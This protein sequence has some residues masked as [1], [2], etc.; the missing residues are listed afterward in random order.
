M[1]SHESRRAFV[2]LAL[3]LEALGCRVSN[4]A[5][6]ANPNIL[7]IT[8]D[9][10]RA[11]HVGSYGYSAAETQ[12]LDGLAKRGLRFDR[13]VT[14]TPLTLPAHASLMT[15]TYPGYHGIRDNGGAALGEG[16]TTLADV[17]RARGYR[18][19][20]FVAAFVLDH[21]WG[22]NQGFDRYSDRV[23]LSNDLQNAGTDSAQRAGSEVVDEATT[24]L[25]EDTSRPFFAWVH[26]Y[27]PHTP[28]DA[29]E[30]VRARFPA[31]TAGAYDAEIAT[32]DEQVGRLVD[33]LS[34]D[35]RLDRT[36]VVALG[37]H[38]ESLGEHQERE[39]GFFIYDATVR[40]PLIV[41]GPGIPS[42]AIADQVRIVDVMPTL[43][44]LA[45]IAIPPAVQGTSLVPVTSGSHVQL[46]ALSETWYPRR[47]FGWSELTA[48]RDDR[49][50]F[51][52]APGRELYDRHL[53]PGE[54]HN[55]AATN[56]ERANSLERAL[57]ELIRHTSSE[58][59]PPS[60]RRVDART[61]ERLRSLGYVGG[62][63]TAKDGNRPLADPKDK[64]A[65]YN[66]LKHAADSSAQGQ[67]DQ[68][69]G[70]VRL[71][72][73]RDPDMVEG[74]TMLGD[75]LRKAKRE[76]DA[77]SAFQR[78]LTL[79]PHSTKSAWNVADIW[80][81]R[82]EFGKAEAALKPV[83][84]EA[85]DRPAFLTKL[86]ECQIELTRYDEA[87]QNLREALQERP[88]QP[89][90][91]YDL[92][93]IHE[94]RRESAQAMSEYEAELKHNPTMDRAHFNLGKLLTASG[95]KSDAARRFQAAVDAN[96]EFSGG[97]LY[98]AKARLDEG[99]LP[100]AEAAARKGLSL[101]P[102]RQ[103][104]PLGHYVLADVYN[105]LGRPQD[106]AREAAIGQRLERSR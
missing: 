34:R 45:G 76:D 40:I 100:R 38:G 48:I 75:F 106:S 4:R 58:A 6:V 22:I 29:P 102:D 28:Y 71:A 89:V 61:A 30:P 80:T 73:D 83:I 94:A 35:G 91:H 86:A 41:A 50:T 11:D 47:H 99:D 90:A 2:S 36:I 13:A 8:I 37:D 95:R 39:H 64:I 21:R 20:G 26:L 44:E 51:I 54:T 97:Y 42:R 74:Y 88:D 46:T 7:L 98:L 67:L 16:Q 24:W 57:S 15:G 66:L 9:T 68:A 31:T 85:A 1:T 52:A 84:M 27:E 72:L 33:R 53:D 17:F 32:A 3:V 104:A 82:R 14:V 56:P 23:R 49:Y 25:A 81:Q 101:N 87:A 10:L 79:D 105:R 69:I 59:K 55:L 5:R 78:A 18:T 77:L 12:A 63:V 92:A 96:P 103:I 43:L 93:L 62:S 60:E 19:G 65:V 70:T